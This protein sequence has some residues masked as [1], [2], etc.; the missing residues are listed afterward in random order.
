ML[1]F[2]TGGLV[3]PENEAVFTSAIQGRKIPCSSGCQDTMPSFVCR[4]E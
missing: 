2:E 1:D 3:D 4:W